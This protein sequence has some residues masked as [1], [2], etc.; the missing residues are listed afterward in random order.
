MATREPIYAALYNLV[1]S[2]PAVKDQ[3]VTTGRLLRLFAQTDQASM[4]A[5]FFFQQGEDHVRDG[6][7]IPDKRTLHCVFVLY[8]WTQDAG[9][10][11][12]TLANTLLDV[13]DDCLNQPGN[14]QNVQT[15]GGLVEHVYIEGRVQIAEGLLQEV[16]VVTVPIAILIP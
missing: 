8:C 14:P 16:T 9:T 5:L 12:A 4:P 13:I 1:V 15:L 2:H 6:K 11:P 7:G 3:F 10:L